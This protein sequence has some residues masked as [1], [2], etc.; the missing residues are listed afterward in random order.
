MNGCMEEESGRKEKR[1]RAQRMKKK[2]KRRSCENGN[3]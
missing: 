2:H 1:I 3:S